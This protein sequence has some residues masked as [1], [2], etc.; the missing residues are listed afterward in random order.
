MVTNPHMDTSGYLVIGCCCTLLLWD[1]IAAKIW[2]TSKTE[3]WWIHQVSR[4]YP[5][6]V[7]IIGILLGHFFAPMLG[8]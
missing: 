2:G 8:E 4:K 5:T 3:S 1:F 6:V 7:L